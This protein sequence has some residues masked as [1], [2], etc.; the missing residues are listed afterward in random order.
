MTTKGQPLFRS[1]GGD[2]AV[3][4][5]VIE[6]HERWTIQRDGIVIASG[7]TDEAGIMIAIATFRALPVATPATTLRVAS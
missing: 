7:P 3:Y 6:G 2:D 1:V 5:L 4:L